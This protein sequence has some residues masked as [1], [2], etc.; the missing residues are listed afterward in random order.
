[1]AVTTLHVTHS[2]NEARKLADCIFRIDGGAV[3]RVSGLPNA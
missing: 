2:M 1:V 3:A